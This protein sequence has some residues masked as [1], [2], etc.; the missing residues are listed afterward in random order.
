MPSEE[1][2]PRPHP[3]A[4]ILLHWRNTEAMRLQLERMLAWSEPPVV[5][6]V[7]NEPWPGA[8]PGGLDIHPVQP[9]ANLGYA[10]G[11]NLAV[12]QI[13]A[14]HFPFVLLMNVDLELRETDVQALRG[15][16]E[17]N[18]GDLAGPLLVEK[19]AG[20]EKCYAGGRDPVRWS[21]TRVPWRHE[22]AAARVL[23]VDYVPGTVCLIRTALLNTLAG[24][25]ESFF[26]S[27]E[28]ADF[29]LRARSL[30]KR[31]VV[32]TGARVPHHTEPGSRSRETLYTYYS[33]RNRFLLIARHRPRQAGWWRLVWLARGLAMFALRVAGGRMQAA[34]ACALALRD[35]WHGNFG[36]TRHVFPT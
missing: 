14:E 28:V 8:M 35:G 32:C 20:Q 33:L 30:G 19:D 6:L 18:E 2:K 5:W 29:C 21:R 26:F 17:R 11:I 22:S 1:T 23:P 25:E 7:E 3:L 12:G 10:G 15:V 4:I 36:P 13:P 27:G 24:L 9:G 34:R 31:C 16:L